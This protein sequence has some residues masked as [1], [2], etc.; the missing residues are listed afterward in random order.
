MQC[1]CLFIKYHKRGQGI[2]TD[3]VG[4]AGFVF[5]SRT[6]IVG[7]EPL[8]RRGGEIIRIIKTDNFCIAPFS[9]L[10]KLTALKLKM[11]GRG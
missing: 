1:S 10:H 4:E 11:R 2:N 8:G 3:E 6:T 9:G 7:L 5:V